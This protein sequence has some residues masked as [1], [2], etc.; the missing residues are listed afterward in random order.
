MKNATD[1]SN[2][3]PAAQTA[4]VLLLLESLKALAD[5]GQGELACRL[6]GRACATLRHDDQQQWQRF[7]ALL[8]RL[9]PRT[10]PVG[11][12]GG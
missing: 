6:A 9:G 11:H 8:H 12:Q 1:D 5:S 10:D 4:L 3:P 2:S 7:N